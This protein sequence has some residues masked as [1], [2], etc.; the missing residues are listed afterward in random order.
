MLK[1]PK[2][3]SF[4]QVQKYAL[5]NGI[6]TLGYRGTVKLHGTN[7][8][9]VRSPEG[10]LSV[11]SRNRVITPD[12]DNAG[13]AAYIA[14]LD[15]GY[16]RA[17]VPEGSALYGEWVGPGIQKGTALSQLPERK[18]VVFDRYYF[19]ARHGVMQG[20]RLA[21]PT[22][23][24]GPFD[25]VDVYFGTTVDF[26]TGDIGPAEF[27][28]EEV[29][30]QCPWAAAR[31]LEGGGEGIVWRPL[32]LVRSNDTCLWFKTKAES[33]LDAGERRPKKAAT[34]DP[35]VV[36]TVRQL[37]TPRRLEQG[38]EYLT[39]MGHPLDRT[40]TGPFCKWVA[41]DVAAEE[42]DLATREVMR[43]VSGK[44]AKWFM[45]EHGQ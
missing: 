33:Y 25:S 7:A 32:W 27:L 18:F 21:S 17:A 13:F 1:F 31:G 28:T 2:I 6:E 19:G 30:R 16:L 37:V 40:S 14:S 24:E 22:M 4:R 12:D 26:V 39:E 8:G 42:P 10:V 3:Q 34:H 29:G 45:R 5:K 23:P 41:G 20:R 9:L 15:D 36:E 44:A 43:L 38:I 11:Q 35:N